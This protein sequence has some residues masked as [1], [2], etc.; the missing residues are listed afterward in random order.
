[1][2]PLLIPPF[3]K[4]LWQRDYWDRIICDENEYNA[5]GEYIINNPQTWQR[6]RFGSD[7]QS[8]REDSMTYG[9]DW[10]ESC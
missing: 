2:S 10:K 3:Q 4:R 5:I 1:M 9:D 8:F 7:D 6:D